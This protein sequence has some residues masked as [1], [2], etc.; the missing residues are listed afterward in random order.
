MRIVNSVFLFFLRRRYRIQITGEELLE[1]NGSKL[2]LPNH[3]AQVDA[4]LLGTV[5]RKHG[6]IVPI[7]SERFTKMPVVGYFLRRLGSVPV[8]DLQM[9]NRD[10]H[11][12]TTISKN[13]GASLKE[14]KLVIIYPAGQIKYQSTE[15]LYNKQSVYNLVRAHGTEVPIIGVRILGLWGSMWS[16]AINGEKP[17]FGLT[18]LKGIGLVFLNL[19][20]FC[21]KRSVTIELVD[22]SKEAYDAAQ[23]DRKSFNHYLEQFYNQH[24]PEADVR[25]R[26]H[27]L[28]WW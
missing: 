2:I 10:P 20:F 6:E 15:K 27:F 22:I 28:Q 25:V 7:V 17:N 4:P 11:V 3:P 26:Y 19:I 23:G 5:L 9:G 14:D 24:G 1:P 16:T 18:F 13:V 8:S 21:P 12:M